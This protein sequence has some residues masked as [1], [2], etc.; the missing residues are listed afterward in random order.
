MPKSFYNVKSSKV[1]SKGKMVGLADL[2][3]NSYVQLNMFIKW[4]CRF[5]FEVPVCSLSVRMCSDRLELIQ[6]AVDSKPFTYKNSQRVCHYL[7]PS[8]I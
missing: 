4:T 2:A 6:K 1:V 7:Y 3:H 5:N 8:S